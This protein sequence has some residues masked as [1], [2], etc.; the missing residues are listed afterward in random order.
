[1][2]I[3][4]S[5]DGVTVAFLMFTLSACA[6]LEQHNDRMTKASS[7]INDSYLS[8]LSEAMTGP[9]AD[10][11]NISLEDDAQAK[12]ASFITLNALPQG[13]SDGFESAQFEM[14][15]SGQPSL[16]LKVEKMPVVEFIH[17]A[18]G[19][20]LEIEYVVDPDVRSAKGGVTLSSGG[21]NS[22]RQ[23]YG[24]VMQVLGRQG[25]GVE[26][27]DGV[28]YIY[29]VDKKKGGLGVTV[30][31]GRNPEAIPRVAGDILQVVDLKYGTNTSLER[32]LNE[33][34]DLKVSLD[35]VKNAL[36]LRGRRS[37]IVKALSFIEMFD[38]PANRGSHIGLVNLTYISTDSFSKQVTSLMKAEGIPIGSGARNNETVVIVPLPNIGSSAV[39][40]GSKE[41][42]DRV[43]YWARL[44]DQPAAGASS[45]YFV[46]KPQFARA[47]E[48]GDSLIQLMGGGRGRARGAASG[49]VGNSSASTGQA[50]D[51]ARTQGFS[52][53][54]FQM[55][56]VER[57][58]SLVFNTTGIEYQRL[59]PLLQQLDV[60]PKQVLLDIVIA[61]VTLKDEFK[62]GVE[63]ALQNGELTSSTLGAFGASTIGGTAFA[64]NGSDG[65]AIAQV[66]QTSQ[67][68]N[69]LSNPTMLV[70]DGVEANIN[71]GSDISV[72]GST[73]FDPLV[74]Q[75]Q[76]TASVYRKTGVDV[77][78][79][80]TVNAEG[81][82]LMKVE[83]KISNAVPNSTG[84]GG[85]P[86]VFERSISTEIV[87]ASGQTV[88][89]GGLVS[90]DVS[91][92]GSGTPGLSS[93]PL[94][95]WL[96][97]SEADTGSRT[98]LVMLITA[99]V[100]DELDE[101]EAIETGF[102]QGLRYLQVSSP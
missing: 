4:S 22:P 24:T 89:L 48:I 60:L 15:L 85:N 9:D 47:S 90:E 71:V 96:F 30:N 26:V 86:D 38:A 78:V 29:N 84:A 10:S 80:P 46:F 7:Q 63:W 95:G 33:L 57:S 37:E 32:T 101:W 67:L 98:E 21:L 2:R 25:L 83:K 91:A 81:V 17:Y 12:A 77:T 64:L 43:R 1:M 20:L 16:D 45:Q 56:V 70:R 36:F 94:L 40:A 18:L 100:I 58:N 74:G 35:S 11:S 79:T 34:L 28:H 99:L 13:N 6:T 72:V 55:V 51:P 54:A 82:I 39:F 97:K 49:A 88:L 5:F 41:L 62:F 68:V 50:P 75:R 3:K 66:L 8:P 73:T 102:N 87:A 31:I 44:V 69:V 27:S 53:D 76:T 42:L 93:A 52:T 19:E 65:E 23:V 92:S 59:I 61:E 14:T